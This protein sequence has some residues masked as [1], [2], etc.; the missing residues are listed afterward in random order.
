[1]VVSDCGRSEEEVA[2]YSSRCVSDGLRVVGNGDRRED[3]EIEIRD[4]RKV[5]YCEQ[6]VE[7]A[8]YSRSAGMRC[9]SLDSPRQTPPRPLLPPTTPPPKAHL[10]SAI[11]DRYPLSI[12]R[13]LVNSPYKPTYHLRRRRRL[14]YCHTAASPS[15]ASRSVWVVRPSLRRTW[16]GKV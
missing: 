15:S 4:E 13:M 3:R 9:I 11:A 5:S 10:T 1:M 2:V 8:L 16:R 12:S 6:E 7:S 14:S